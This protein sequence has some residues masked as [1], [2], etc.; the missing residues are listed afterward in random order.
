MTDCMPS[1]LHATYD[2]VVATRNRADAL[3]LS[4][5]LMIGQSPPPDRL[6]IVDASDDPEPV[7][8]VVSKATAIWSG[9][10]VLLRAPKGL[11]R[12]R[13][14]GLAKVTSPVVFFLDDDSLL[15]PGSAAAI[16]AIYD[17][18]TFGRIAGV[19]AAEA[20]VSPVSLEGAGYAMSTRHR[21][22][23]RTRILRNRIERR[24]TV[25]KPALN[26][27]RALN[28]H[29][30]V[31]NWLADMDAK[32]V[33]YMTGFRMTFRTA[34]IRDAGFDEALGGY[35]LDEDI[36]ASFSAMRSGLVV[37]TRRARVYHHRCPGGRGSPFISGFMSVFNR[38]YVLEKHANGLCGSA[39]FRRAL[40][41]QHPMFLGLK[42]ASLVPGLYQPD[43]WRTFLGA[44]AGW[45]AARSL[46]LTQPRRVRAAELRQ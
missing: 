40:R 7:R 10:T 4:L 14:R 27:G 13:N 1:S 21:R 22:E 17:R 35:A 8:D 12:Q 15:H 38:I 32:P 6:I 16:L 42:L 31:P 45:R 19:A 23:A 9:K 18:D 46:I 34:A 29:H 25:L 30:A 37:G 43:G 41:V 28:A 2:I 11:P 36:D 24:M 33:E 3:A 20:H 39:A 5:P 26:L 44:L